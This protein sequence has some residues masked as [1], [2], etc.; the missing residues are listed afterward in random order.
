MKQEDTP[1]VN[2]GASELSADVPSVSQNAE[3]VSNKKKDKRKR[4]KSIKKRTSMGF[5]LFAVAILFV[6][7]GIFLVFLFGVYGSMLEN[8]LKKVGMR[9]A[10]SFPKSVDEASLSAYGKSMSDFAQR[11]SVAVTVFTEKNGE[12][13]VLLNI[14]TFGNNADDTQDAF[15]AIMDDIDFKDTFVAGGETT[16]A[17]TDAGRVLCYCIRKRVSGSDGGYAYLLVA[18]AY[19]I[20]NSQ[21]MILIWALVA[22]TVVVLGGA[23]VTSVF[24]SR[25]QTRLLRGFSKNAKRL[26]DGDYGAVFSGGGYEE[27]E[28]LATAL[29]TARDEIE[30]AEHMRR[31]M[32]AN[33][34]HDIR[35]PLTM[36]RAY[37]EMLRDMPVDPEKRKKTADVIIA[38][39]D[40]LDVM[41]GDILD[42]SKLQA[43][44]AEFEYDRIDIAEI[45][46]GMLVDF[47]IYSERDGIKFETNIDDHAFAVC[48]RV[49]ISQV[50][51]NL[52]INAVN[53]C[54]VDKKVMISVKSDDSIVRVE[55]GDHGK[56]IPPEELESVWDR[57]YRAAH[58]RRSTVGSGLGLSICKNILIA[59][60]AK[61]GVASELGIGTTFWFELPCK[62]EAL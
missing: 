45:A 49:R 28:T 31:D 6:L 52:V 21:T 10:S 50:L 38:E 57:Y 39:S 26:A 42:L 4:F 3:T 53:Y 2:S 15:I 19:D 62:K 56:G 29:N 36:I 40:R 61:Y 23:C 9:A 59:H 27:Y 22:C 55:I 17:D 13:D 14:D 5:I 44:V 60:G 16:R 1:S 32:I 41:T 33:V 30:K 24:M 8:D 51:Y 46:R 54:G 18:E 48:D 20:F 12:Y 34:S 37:A 7:W 11:E 25:Y 35:T 58:T 43:G 47:E